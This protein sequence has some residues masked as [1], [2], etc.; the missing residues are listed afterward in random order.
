MNRKKC[1]TRI[2][3][4]FRL[5]LSQSSKISKNH[6]EKK[7]AKKIRKREAPV[8]KKGFYIGKATTLKE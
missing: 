4:S 5:Q 6:D 8:N 7:M 2:E 1:Q 3:L